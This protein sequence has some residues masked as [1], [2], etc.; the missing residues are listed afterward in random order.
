[1]SIWS[2]EAIIIGRQA[3][4]HIA[5]RISAFARI[6][7]V[8]ISF[9]NCI[10]IND[11]YLWRPTHIFAHKECRHRPHIN[12]YMRRAM[13]N[14]AKSNWHPDMIAFDR[15]ENE[16]KQPSHNVNHKNANERKKKLEARS[17]WKQYFF[18][19][20]NVVQ[21]RCPSAWISNNV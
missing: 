10:H 19:E 21:N 13:F 14:G 4:I 7:S 3:A 17:T 9:S 6:H 20:K 15:R 11:F 8:L 1:M 18:P 12:T 2:S 16:W 5:H